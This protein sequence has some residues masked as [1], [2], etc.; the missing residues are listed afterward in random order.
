MFLKHSPQV[1]PVIAVAEQRDQLLESSNIDKSLEWPSIIVAL[2][3]W[4]TLGFIVQ[5]HEF[6]GA[7]KHIEFI[8]Q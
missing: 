2:G 5:R 1:E 6:K 3:I 7:P 8:D 4:I